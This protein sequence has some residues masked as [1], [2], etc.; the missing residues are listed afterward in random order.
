M[1]RATLSGQGGVSLGNPDLMVGVTDLEV[2]FVDGEAVLYA[3]G[4]GGGAL[5]RFS[6]G[7]GSGAATLSDSWGI[8][9]RFLQ[10]ESTD[11][12]LIPGPGGTTHVLLAGLND[13]DLQG[14]VDTGTGLGGFT[15]FDAG[16]FDLGQISNIT[17]SPDGTQG[18]A[19]L[20]VGGLVELAFDGTGQISVS[21]PEGL[22]GLGTQAASA[23]SWVTAGGVDYA[24]VTYAGSDQIALFSPGGG[25]GLVHRDTL[26]PEDGIWIDSPTA[27]STIQGPDGVTYVV[28]AA[29]GSSSLTV[30]TIEGNALVPVDHVIDTLDTRFNEASQLEVMEIGGQPYVVA[31][32]SDQGLTVFSL[33]PG[34]QLLEVATVAASLDTPLNGITDIEVVVTGAGARIFVATQG[35]PYLV[36]FVFELENPGTTRVGGAGADMLTGMGGDD[37]IAGGAGDDTL[38]GGA[39]DDVITDGTGLDLLTGGAGADTFV[40]GADGATDRVTDYQRGVDAIQLRAPAPG[41]GADDILVISRSWGAEIHLGTEVL[42]VY[43]ADGNPL[44]WNDFEGGFLTTSASISVDLDDYV[45]D[46]G[47]TGPET[48]SDLGATLHFDRPDFAVT[49]LEEPDIGPASASGAGTGQSDLITGGLG[50]DVLIGAGGFDTIEGGGGHDSISGGANGDLLYGG[51]AMM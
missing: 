27:V 38:E 28:M 16:S 20:R 30:M 5:T 29:S 45:D 7:D 21:T 18:L 32:G 33:M 8:P 44:G 43:S 39:G 10:L 49:P 24:V 40:F 36:E 48:G 2:G 11:I 35:A 12:L 34:G 26:S 14:R 46:S 9:D 15:V 31:A 13:D 37:L 25:G 19:S 47:N 51:A 22:G 6:L 17:L 3:A 4:R 42:E 50:H 1:V 41:M 23:V